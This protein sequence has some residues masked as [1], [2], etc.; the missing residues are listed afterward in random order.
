MV[1]LAQNGAIVEEPARVDMI[2][3]NA[4]CSKDGKKGTF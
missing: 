2:V 1:V 3:G 4:L